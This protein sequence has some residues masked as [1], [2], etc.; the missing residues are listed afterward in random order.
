VHDLYAREDGC[1]PLPKKAISDRLRYRSGH[2]WLE[3]LELDGF[4]W[5]M[6]KMEYLV[7][8]LEACETLLNL[9]VRDCCFAFFRTQFA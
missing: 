9:T 8:S 7:Q 6:T 5:H 1:A 3:T 4:H 2:V